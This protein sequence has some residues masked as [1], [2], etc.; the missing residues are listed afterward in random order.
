MFSTA[1]FV[2]VAVLFVLLCA[3]L[4]WGLR[5]NRSERDEKMRYEGRMEIET[6]YQGTII[7][8]LRNKHALEIAQLREAQNMRL[9]LLYGTIETLRRQSDQLSTALTSAR[10]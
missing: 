9:I 1:F 2:L 8:E 7:P 3:L 4:I 6:L 10:Q 5:K